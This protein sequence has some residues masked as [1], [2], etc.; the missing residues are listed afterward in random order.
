MLA[1]ESENVVPLPPRG[2]DPP[3]FVI[4]IPAATAW[5]DGLV[6]LFIDD[7]YVFTGTYR[8]AICMAVD[9]G[10]HTVGKYFIQDTGQHKVFEMRLR[11]KSERE[12]GVKATI[13]IRPMPSQENENV[14]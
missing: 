3:K 12:Q 1:R 13:A 8:E 4:A 5:D 10:L 14:S 2:S 6:S 11:T 9:Y 7:R